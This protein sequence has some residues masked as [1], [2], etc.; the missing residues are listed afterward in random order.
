MT[1]AVVTCPV[2][3]KSSSTVGDYTLHVRFEDPDDHGDS[4]NVATGIGIPSD[5]AGVLTAN[6]TDYFR[7]IVARTGTLQV[8]T[9]SSMDTVGVLEY[10]LASLSYSDDDSGEHGNFRIEQTVVAGIYYVRVTGY[11]GS[12]GS[13]TLHVRLI[14]GMADQDGVVN[15]AYRDGSR[16]R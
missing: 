12:T 16:R 9:T 14:A 1:Q 2:T 3:G 6:D 7:V 15:K 4:Q 10:P 11:R 13:Y 8:Y 5:T